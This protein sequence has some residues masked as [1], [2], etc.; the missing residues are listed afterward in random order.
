MPEE[1]IKLLVQGYNYKQNDTDGEI[2][3]K[4]ISSRED[5]EARSY[6][7]NELSSTKRNDVRQLIKNRRYTTIF[8]PIRD[9][10]GLFANIQ[11]GQLHRLLG[12][13]C[14]EVLKPLNGYSQLAC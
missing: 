11:L 3:R 10:P 6:W 9:I 4:I 13:G 12:M 5:A 8:D 7:L 14:D 2:F 1:H